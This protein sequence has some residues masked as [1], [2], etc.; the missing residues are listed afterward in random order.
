MS[1]LPAHMRLRTLPDP[2][3]LPSLDARTA[4][5][6]PSL[7]LPDDVAHPPRILL[8]YGSLRERSYSRLVVEEA[9]RLVRR[10]GGEPRI[11]DPSDLPPPGLVNGDDH[12]AVR[13]LRE[14]ALWSEGQIW[15]SPERHG[16]RG[17]P[18]MHRTPVR[19]SRAGTFPGRR[20]SR[21]RVRP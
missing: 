1:R 3:F 6:R 13:E 16:L 4:G 5:T 17:G 11:F 12:P 10:F 20:R 2:D 15:C 19:R 8:L 14:H 21:P 9:A 18:S 7:G